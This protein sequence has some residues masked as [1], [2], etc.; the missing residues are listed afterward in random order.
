MNSQLVFERR[1]VGLFGVL[2]VARLIRKIIKKPQT[3]WKWFSTILKQ[4]PSQSRLLYW[5]RHILVI[6]SVLSC[7][8]LL[9]KP[10]WSQES[11]ETTKEWIDIVIALDVSGSMGADDFVP[12][13]LSVAKQNVEKF[14]QTLESDRVGLVVF[15][16]QPFTSVPLTFD[17]EIT[18]QIVSQLSIETINQN[19]RGLNGTAIGD[20]ILAS[21]GILEKWI[22][23][24]EWDEERE[25]VIIMVTDGAATAWSLDPEMASA[26]AVEQWVTIYTV[27]IWSIEWWSI[28]YNTPF[29][30]RRQPVWGVDEK[31]LKNIAD[32][33]WGTYWRATNEKTFQRI[34]DE[35]SGLAKSE[36]Q[37]ESVKTSLPALMRLEWVV[38]FCVIWLLVLGLIWYCISRSTWSRKYL[39]WISVCLVVLA[40]VLIW[41]EPISQELETQQEVSI[42]LD[43]STSM[44]VQDITYR[45]QTIS[46]LQ[47]AKTLIQR[48][49]DSIDTAER[50]M[51]VFA[52]ASTTVLPITNDRELFLTFLQWVDRES[53]LEWWSDLWSAIRQA[54]DR[55][56]QDTPG[57]RRRVVVVSDGGEESVTLD[58]QTIARI[59]EQSIELLV[60]GVWTQEWWPII[61]WTDRFGNPIVKQY[62]WQTVIAKLW[63]SILTSVATQWWGSYERLENID[64]IDT[65]ITKLS[66]KE[67]N[68]IWSWLTVEAWWYDGL[69]IIILFITIIFSQGWWIKQKL[70]EYF[71]I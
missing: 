55:F 42:V 41:V 11:Q 17:Y 13:R 22:Q 26:Y 1:R 27:G 44:K 33:T 69:L 61:E 62:Q 40:A 19:V 47:A 25:Q 54:I 7:M 56:V 10:T 63:E 28:S 38:V 20:A 66:A 35:L 70:T 34:F 53:V 36:I 32:K 30:I 31:A 18:S 68:I 59:T 39:W 6:L 64:D 29:G 4:L 16:W 23:E 21:L 71:N 51:Q 49:V 24:W 8:I 65:L 9:M 57:I 3:L 60:V 14:V 50:G 48:A 5:F 52:W 12:D 15:A 46:R 43:V 2:L 45:N 58:E 67:W 37:T